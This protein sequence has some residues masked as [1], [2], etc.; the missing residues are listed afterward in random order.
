MPARPL[1]P[2]EEARV[3]AANPR[4]PWRSGARKLTPEE[5][6]RVRAQRASFGQNVG[7][8]FSQIPSGFNRW[9]A[10]NF[11]SPGGAYGTDTGW[12]W[13][14]PSI[15]DPVEWL[16][17]QA[18]MPGT[19]GGRMGDYV[20]STI[21]QAILPATTPYMVPARVAAS[22]AA[23]TSNVVSRGVG[24]MLQGV[25][26]APA[27]AAAG[28]LASALGAGTGGAVATQLFPDDP[29]AEAS[30]LLAGGFAPAAAR[31][32]PAG[33]A[34]R[35]LGAAT[36]LAFD[37]LNASRAGRGLPP[38]RKVWGV[39]VPT[40][41]GPAVSQQLAKDLG[42]EGMQNIDRAIEMQR[43]VPGTN[44][45]LAEMSQD[46]GLMVFQEKIGHTATGNELRQL[47]RRRT[48][49]MEATYRFAQEQG[50]EGVADDI[51]AVI[52]PIKNKIDDLTGAVDRLAIKNEQEAILLAERLPP[53][54]R[55][56]LGVRLRD[57]LLA[58]REAARQAFDKE[59]SDLGLDQID[60]SLQFDAWRKDI[61][62]SPRYTPDSAFVDARDYDEIRSVLMRG[63][64]EAEE[65]AEAAMQ[66][67]TVNDLKR[68]RSVLMDRARDAKA[69]ANPNAN[70]ARLFESLRADLD[71]FIDDGL[72]GIGDSPE[73]IAAWRDWSSRY[74]TGYI[75]RFG[76]GAAFKVRQKDQR[77]F[78]VTTDEKVADTFFKA[79]DVTAA[80][81]FKHSFG[82]DP[83]PM[84]ALEAVAMDSLRIAAVRDGLIDPKRFDSWLRRHASVLD[85]FPDLKSKVMGIRQA[86][87][88]IA[89]RHAQLNGRRRSIEDSYL[90]KELRSFDATSKTAEQ[91][92]RNIMADP[93]RV[94]WVMGRLRN[95]PE[96]LAA[97]KRH[98]W[99]GVSSQSG[100]EIKAFMEENAETLRIVLDRQHV[101]D[102]ATIADM[103]WMIESIPPPRGQPVTVDL[104]KRLEQ[105]TG[106]NVP[107]WMS[108]WLHV[109]AG[110]LSGPIAYGESSARFLSRLLSN[111]YDRSMREALF[112]PE[113]ARRMVDQ[114]KDP[115]PQKAK[116]L[117]TTLGLAFT[118]DGSGSESE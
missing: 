54:E 68:L 102:L 99:D 92:M 75:E 81:Q 48:Q 118:A 17:D 85:E 69:G 23:P 112:N 9:A 93:R 52:D 27:K 24:A 31:F 58:E 8:F 41:A 82:A 107:Q 57:Q 35:G 96:A 79:G 22:L 18:A 51:G 25:Q 67:V 110:R 4:P 47:G 14:I 20:G 70:K 29:L 40:R 91:T 55:A 117:Y 59:A 62:G 89:K 114:I 105:T 78:Y 87:D 13:G 97:F 15:T 90:A 64:K 71:R 42:A 63:M 116:R 16:A 100:A 94:R 21:G 32:T 6:A 101:D 56:E 104:M 39:P 50:P 11:G 46:P 12:T 53:A 77:D 38:V 103:R 106:M 30:G 1:T 37:T 65:G 84:E 76:K 115:S 72:E 5:V 3:R 43:R 111:R 88:A 108:R 80:R 45:T 73:Q 98:V 66:A 44:L 26:N 95:K 28:E 36:G 33:W 113:V 10:R 74:K 34:A 61:L 19:V 60:V 86:E 7:E 109:Q 49:S 2:E 83:E